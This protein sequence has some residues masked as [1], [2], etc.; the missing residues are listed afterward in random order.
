MFAPCLLSLCGRTHHGVRRLY[1]SGAEGVTVPVPHRDDVPYRLRETAGPGTT[2]PAS[3]S[4][5]VAEQRSSDHGSPCASSP[6]PSAARCNDTGP[7]RAQL[8]CTLLHTL[9]S[10]RLLR[11]PD[12]LPSHGSSTP[13]LLSPP[14]DVSPGS[15]PSS[16]RTRTRSPRVSAAASTRADLRRFEGVGAFHDD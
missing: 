5:S 3:H 14:P 2:Y 6:G 9:Q 15:T 4:S 8:L 13:N 11:M 12:L 10:R 16:L 1:S 7:S